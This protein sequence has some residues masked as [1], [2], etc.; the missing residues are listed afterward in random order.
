MV[1]YGF[2]SPEFKEYLK[3]MVEWYE[4]GLIDPEYP[5]VDGNSMDAKMTGEIAGSFWGWVS[6]GIGRYMNLMSEKLFYIN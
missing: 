6:S 1:K 5:V 2:T 3:V 4:L